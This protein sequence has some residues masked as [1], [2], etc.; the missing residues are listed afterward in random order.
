MTEDEEE[1]E[2][3]EA[4]GRRRRREGGEGDNDGGG[5]EG[6]EALYSGWMMTDCGKQHKV[7][8]RKGRG[9]GVWW[10]ISTAYRPVPG[11]TVARG[12]GQHGGEVLYCVLAGTVSVSVYVKVWVSRGVGF[13]RGGLD[14]AKNGPAAARPQTTEGEGTGG[15]SG[16]RQSGAVGTRPGWARWEK[17]SLGAKVR[18]GLGWRGLVLRVE[19][20]GSARSSGWR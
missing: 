1:M 16:T 14:W 8:E 9:G 2:E 11:R 10:M 18:S 5:E 15:K 13:G 12:R 17:R 20:A 19:R 4:E 3:S 7:L 6:R